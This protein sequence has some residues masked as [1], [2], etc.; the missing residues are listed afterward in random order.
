MGY[1][2]E[3]SSSEQIA[4]EQTLSMLTNPA[5][6]S[7]AIESLGSSAKS[8]DSSAKSLAIN[9]ANY[10]KIYQLTSKILQRI[11][12]KNGGD[13]TKLTQI[14]SEAKSNP[15]A[16]ANLMSPDER[17]ALSAIALDIEKS[18]NSLSIN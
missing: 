7:Q 3:L 8:A 16:F 6:R 5:A 15:T 17:K 2:A 12:Q 11:V 18:Q 13:I 14:L 1:S 10:E 4:L 9:E